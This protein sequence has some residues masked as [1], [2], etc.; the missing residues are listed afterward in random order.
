VSETGNKSQTGESDRSVRLEIR[1]R[2]VSE[3]G[4]KSQTGESDWK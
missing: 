3:T 2:P 1:V 4:N